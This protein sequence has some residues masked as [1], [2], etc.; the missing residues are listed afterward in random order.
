MKL[1]N[2]LQIETKVWECVKSGLVIC[3]NVMRVCHLPSTLVP[4]FGR[5]KRAE[6]GDIELWLMF[7][8]L[9]IQEIE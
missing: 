5:L 8:M 7:A 4:W 1:H 2:H 3:Y 9:V 6:L